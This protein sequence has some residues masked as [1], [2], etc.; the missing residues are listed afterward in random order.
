MTPLYRHVTFIDVDRTSKEIALV[1]ALIFICA[2]FAKVKL[3]S[4]PLLLKIAPFACLLAY[5]FNQWA[6][7]TENVVHQSILAGVCAMAAVIIYEHFSLEHI[8]YFANAFCVGILVQCVFGFTEIVG[9]NLFHKILA[10]T[11]RPGTRDWIVDWVR[12]TKFPIDVNEA[13]NRE[14]FVSPRIWKEEGLAGSLG[15][16]NIYGA[17]IATGLCF[18]IRKRWA[19]LLPIVAVFMALSNSMGAIISSLLALCSYLWINSG[20]SEKACFY[21]LISIVTI[22]L[23]AVGT[24]LTTMDSGRMA[25]WTDIIDKIDFYS[26]KGVTKFI[27]GH[28]FG[29]FGDLGLKYSGNYAHSEHSIYFTMFTTFGIVGVVWLLMIFYGAI[30]RHPEAWIAPAA[31]LIMCNGVT[32]FIFHQASLIIPLIVIM[33]IAISSNARIYGR[34]LER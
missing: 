7:M 13:L 1:M 34:H 9:V 2:T 14:V 4:A 27:I 10:Y 30:G 25:I 21:G 26:I 29:W 5:L 15:N 12:I 18:F 6:P 19:L 20:K 33:V 24:G 28:G 22:G 23:I 32:N 17:Y 11:N 16:G 31:L 3:R 8:N